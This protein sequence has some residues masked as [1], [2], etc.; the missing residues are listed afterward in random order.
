MATYTTYYDHTPIARAAGANAA[1]VPAY[2][3]IENVF[4]ASKRKLAATDVVELID[5][6]AGT[7]VQKV[8]VQV[9]RGEEGTLNVGDADAANGYVA[10][11]N[12]GTTGARIMGAGSLATGKFYATGGK[13]LLTVPAATAF[14]TLRIKVQ[15]AVVQIG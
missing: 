9:E 10:A 13:L 2:T 6:P 7:L 8:F 15:L 12:V 5:I 1:G 11:G 14:E 4:D 3:V